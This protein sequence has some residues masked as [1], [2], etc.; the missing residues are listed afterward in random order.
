MKW[1]AP[2]PIVSEW[3]SKDLNPFPA[4][5]LEG[6]PPLLGRDDSSWHVAYGMWPQITWGPLMCRPL[7]P[8]SEW[9][10]PHPGWVG[11]CDLPL[12]P[13][14]PVTLSTLMVEKCWGKSSGFHLGSA[15]PL[16]NH[17]LKPQC[18]SLAL[19]ALCLCF[20]CWRAQL[21]WQEGIAG[22]VWVFKEWTVVGD[23]CSYLML[24]H[25]TPVIFS[26]LPDCFFIK[27]QQ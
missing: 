20:S 18:A 7:G 15:L 17:R 14:W 25:W 21:G 26:V 10:D 9:L 8:T 23:K 24:T 22:R 12:K 27:G 5:C 3:H 11:V 19:T 13:A 16:F 4:L 6:L 2:G 1:L